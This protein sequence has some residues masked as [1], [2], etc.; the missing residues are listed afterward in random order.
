MTR[1][2]YILTS[3]NFVQDLEQQDAI[4]SMQ[5]DASTFLLKLNTFSR[6]PFN[7]DG[8]KR[9]IGDIPSTVESCCSEV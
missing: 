6:L 3:I 2:F 5:I 8:V 4:E 9:G 1:Y 7:E